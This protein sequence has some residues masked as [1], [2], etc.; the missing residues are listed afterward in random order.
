MREIGYQEIVDTVA[1]LSME[2]NSK[3]VAAAENPLGNTDRLFSSF[4]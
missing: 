2:V 3:E 4:S 1:R